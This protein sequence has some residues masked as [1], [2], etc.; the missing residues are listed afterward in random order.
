MFVDLNCCCATVAL[1]WGCV[2]T[3]FVIE[4]VVSML[5]LLALVQVYTLF[6]VRM[7]FFFRFWLHLQVAVVYL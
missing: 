7:G 3:Y 6:S 1:N 4:T 5:V 2:C